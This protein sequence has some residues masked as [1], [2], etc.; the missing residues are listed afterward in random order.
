[1]ARTGRP[2]FTLIELLVVI[3]VIALLLSILMPALAKARSQAM[4]LKCSSNLRQQYLAIMMYIDANEDE[5]PC[6]DDPLSGGYWLWMGRWAKFVERY[7]RTEVTADNPS[8]MVC[9]QDITYRAGNDPFSYAYSM[10]FY[11]S[12]EQINLMSSVE[13]TYMVMPPTSVP[14]RLS[15]VRRPSG[16]ILIG[17]WYSNHAPV[18]GDNGWWCWVGKRNYLFADGR[19]EYLKAEDI[20]MAR[21]YLPD[22]NL[23]FDGIRGI[24]WPAE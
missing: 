9:P 6:T 7:I 11:H 18:T 20:R 22:A 24:D 21:D 19:I 14:Q 17:E 1:M 3:A 12:P 8:I 13:E 23:T 10:T 16:K 2:G 15:N 5:F 4:W